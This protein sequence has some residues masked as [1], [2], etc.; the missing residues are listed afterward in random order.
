MSEVVNLNKARKARARADAVAKAA[1]NRIKFGRPKFETELEKKRREKAAS[2]L[3]G[4][5]RDPEKP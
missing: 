2:A 5:R 3:D 4:N 1:E